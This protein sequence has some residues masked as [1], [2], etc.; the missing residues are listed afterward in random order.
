MNVKM[1]VPELGRQLHHP[2]RLPIT[3]RFWLPKIAQQPLLGVA[4]LL[5]TDDCH[6]T[7]VELGQA[8]DD[9]LVVTVSP[10]AVQLHEIGEQQRNANPCV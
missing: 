1:G 2:E 5:V 6:R 9:R 3:F 7:P 4:S 8:R 10:V